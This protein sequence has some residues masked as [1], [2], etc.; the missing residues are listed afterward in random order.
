MG[1]RH[2]VAIHAV[3]LREHWWLIAKPSLAWARQSETQRSETDAGLANNSLP[4]HPWS[5]TPWFD[6]AIRQ[7]A[8]FRPSSFQFC[9]P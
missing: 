8:D 7:C 2:Q 6:F 1:F 9:G 3:A 5:M 4:V